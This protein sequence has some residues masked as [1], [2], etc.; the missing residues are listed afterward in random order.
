MSGRYV[1]QPVG[2]HYGLGA[3]LLQRLTAIVMV[4]YT[5]F[6]GAA[7]LAAAPATHAEWKALLSDGLVRVTTLLFVLALLYHAWVGVRDVLMDYVKPIGARLALQS[8]V[9]F[10]LVAYVVWAATIL[11][12]R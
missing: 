10:V 4:A 8:L 12:G 6:M 2:A 7:L 3:W 9:G 11:W 1:K 5:L